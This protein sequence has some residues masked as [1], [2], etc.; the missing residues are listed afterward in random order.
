[1]I[2]QGAR[3]WIATGHTS[4]RKGMQGLALVVQQRLGRDPHCGDLFVFRGRNGTLIKIIWHDGIG[5]SLYTKR[6]DRGHFIWPSA[7][8]GKIPLTS[9]QLSCLLEGVDWRNPVYTWRPA[10]AG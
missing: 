7:K 1:M 5:M 4:M 6:L 8:E 2:P 3:I 9:S 10:S